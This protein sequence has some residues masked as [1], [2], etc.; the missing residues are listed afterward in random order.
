MV[1]ESIIHQINR[2]IAFHQNIFSF[3]ANHHLQ[4]F[5]SRVSYCMQ[6]SEEN[7]QISE[8]ELSRQLV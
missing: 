5:P 6:T 2:W 8:Q 7:T 1:L 4:K 3:A